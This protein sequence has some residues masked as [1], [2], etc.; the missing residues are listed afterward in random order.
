MSRHVQDVSSASSLSLNS[1]KHGLRDS[2]LE[3]ADAARSRVGMGMLSHQ[4]K[5]TLPQADCGFSSM[6]AVRLALIP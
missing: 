4:E 3:T 1:Q 5:L 6:S 2:T